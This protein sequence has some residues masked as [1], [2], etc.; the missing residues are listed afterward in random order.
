MPPLTD[1]HALVTGASGAIGSAIAEAL[2]DRGA[3]LL[4]VGRDS[5]RLDTLARRLRGRAPLRALL[6]DLTDDDAIDRIASSALGEFGGVDVLIHAAGEYASGPLETS[7]VEAFDRQ[8]RVNAR[9]PYLLTQRLLQ[10]L[11]ARK[12]EIVFV[13]SSAVIAPRAGIGAYA[14][15]KAALRALA[16]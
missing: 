6:A 12:G 2:A 13:N 3:R 4:A 8:L 15:S 5:A 11:L 7:P 9:A 16:E 1:R 14:A 10:S